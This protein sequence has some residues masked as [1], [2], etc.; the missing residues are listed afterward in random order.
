MKHPT[1]ANQLRECAYNSLA[2][3]KNP[4]PCERMQ[5]ML[6]DVKKWARD[7]LD[8]SSRAHRQLKE[9]V[10]SELH[11]CESMLGEGVGLAYRGLRPAD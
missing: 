9:N 4:T 3:H 7:H 8:A 2:R 5:A 1:T 6:R 10:M 11:T